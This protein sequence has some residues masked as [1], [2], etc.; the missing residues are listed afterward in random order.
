MFLSSV[1]SRRLNLDNITADN[2]VVVL[3]YLS[4]G[5]NWKQSCGIGYGSQHPNYYMGQLLKAE[6]VLD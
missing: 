3:P 2:P 5:E 1:E 6:K 4:Y